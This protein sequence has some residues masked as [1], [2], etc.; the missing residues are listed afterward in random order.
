MYVFSSHHMLHWYCNKRTLI[1]YEACGWSQ[2]TPPVG[3]RHPPP[4]PS[5]RALTRYHLGA[6]KSRANRVK[7]KNLKN[8][9]ATC[10]LYR[11]TCLPIVTLCYPFICPLLFAFLLFFFLWCYRKTPKISPGACIFQR[12][13][14]RGLFLEG[15][16][17]GGAYLR[18]DICVSKSIG[19]AL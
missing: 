3:T 7:S 8:D 11:H 1:E 6:W 16:I 5:P 19:L 15:L 10:L 4:L 14:L 9:Y 17:F 13:F 18:R 2:R 12:P